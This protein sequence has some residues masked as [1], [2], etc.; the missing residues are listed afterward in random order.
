MESN[1]GSGQ[2]QMPAESPGAGKTLRSSPCGPFG[3]ITS[4]NCAQSANNELES[5]YAG[6]LVN[7]KLVF[8]PKSRAI[9]PPPGWTSNALYE[10]LWVSLSVAIP[11]VD[12]EE[13]NLEV[14]RRKQV[15]EF[16]WLVAGVRNI[17]LSC[18]AG[19]LSELVCVSWKPWWVPLKF[20]NENGHPSFKPSLD[21]AKTKYASLEEKQRKQKRRF[22]H[23]EILNFLI[24]MKTSPW[25]PFYVY[26]VLEFAIIHDEQ[27]NEIPILRVEFCQTYEH[28]SCL[29]NTVE[30]WKEVYE[31]RITVARTLLKKTKNP[32]STKMVHDYMVC[33]TD[34]LSQ[35]RKI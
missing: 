32:E 2:R 30:T 31:R 10:P 4:G 17:V 1:S 9:V 33:A 7:T 28:C 24:S 6:P 35:L 22:I 26:K 8:S 13:H 15:R 20:I 3:P 12:L 18:E 14:V 25:T 5:V 11:I 27:E 16:A 21:E 29:T 34:L 19:F 23:P